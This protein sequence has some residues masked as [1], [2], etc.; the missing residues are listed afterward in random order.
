MKVWIEFATA[1]YL[2]L[3]CT[4]R[5]ESGRPPRSVRSEMFIEPKM[6]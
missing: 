6:N 3:D 5:D 1:C 4:A 2:R